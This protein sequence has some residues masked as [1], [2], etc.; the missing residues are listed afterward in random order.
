[1]PCGPQKVVK[2]RHDLLEIN[3]IQDDTIC[4]DNSVFE[5]VF[6]NKIL[7][8]RPHQHS[9]CKSCRCYIKKGVLV[10]NG[11]SYQCMYEL[12]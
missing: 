9:K 3:E 10:V 8:Q 4:L 11:K 5:I 2:P 12:V 7:W 1:L 6:G